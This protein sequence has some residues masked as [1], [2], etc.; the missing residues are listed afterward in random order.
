MLAYALVSEQNPGVRLR[1]VKA[2]DPQRRDNGMGDVQTALLAAVKT[3]ENV[4]VRQR[5]LQLLRQYPFTEEVKEA[6]LFV[7]T[8][9]ENPRLRIEAINSLEQAAGGNYDARMVDALQDRARSDNNDYI[10]LRAQTAL[11]EVNQQ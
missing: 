11:Q 4:A 3:D 1:A 9:D 10:R 7:L 2:I 6:L 8:T 5:A